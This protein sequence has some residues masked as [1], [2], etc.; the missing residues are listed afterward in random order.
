M[1]RKNKVGIDINPT[2]FSHS[3]TDDGYTLIATDGKIRKYWVEHVK[4]CREICNY[5]GKEQVSNWNFKTSSVAPFSSSSFV[6]PTNK[7]GV[8]LFL[9][10]ATTF[11]FMFSSAS[12]KR[13]LL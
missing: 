7:S 6:S 10:A 13:F 5:I 4:R 3:F 8:I 11:L 2:L 9:S 1:G 12:P